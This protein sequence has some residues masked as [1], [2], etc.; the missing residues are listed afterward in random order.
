[1][2]IK[3]PKQPKTSA[4]SRSVKRAALLLAL[5]L[6]VTI[7]TAVYVA[8]DRQQQA[9]YAAEQQLDAQDK[10]RFETVRKKVAILHERL[11]VAA[12]PNE[13]WELSVSCSQGSVKVGEPAKVCFLATEATVLVKSEAQARGLIKKYRRIFSDVPELFK[14]HKS[15]DPQPQDFPQGLKEGFVTDSYLERE[16]NM[17]CSGSFRIDA[18]YESVDTTTAFEISFRCN[19]SARELHYPRNDL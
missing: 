9:Q 2:K 7:A 10:Q 16:T 4:R 13:E 18:N 15:Y 8:Y 17:V 6:I 19:D 12:G 3:Q 14:K 1:M 11:Q 5:L